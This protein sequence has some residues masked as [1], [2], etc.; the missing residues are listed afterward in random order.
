MKIRKGIFSAE[1]G[2][3]LGSASLK[4]SSLLYSSVITIFLLEKT[5][6]YTQI[7]ILWSILLASQMISDYPTGGLADKIGRLKVFMLGMVVSGISTIIY[8]YGYGYIWVLYIGAILAGFGE[9]QISGTLLPWVIS[10]CKQSGGYEKKIIVRLVSQ[11]QMITSGIGILI[12]LCIY[13]IQ[14]DEAII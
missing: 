3:L 7:G 10:E 2:Y 12:G 11:N 5:I 14:L 13:R 4:V 1:K 6:D 9:A 8:V